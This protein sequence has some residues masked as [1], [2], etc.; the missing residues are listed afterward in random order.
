[1]LTRKELRAAARNELSGFWTMPV[2][3]TLVYFLINSLCGVPSVLSTAFP[4]NADVIVGFSSAYCVISILVILP[5]SYGFYLCFLKFLRG[6]KEDTVER[7]FDGFKTYGRALGVVILQSIFTILWTL[8]LIV[9]GIIKAFAYSMSVYISHD[10]PELSA[11]ECID[12]SV[13][14]MKGHKWEL[15]VLYLSFIGWF[16]L[17]LPTFG[18]GFLWLIP[19]VNVTVSKFYEE[20]KAQEEAELNEQRVEIME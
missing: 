15:F 16:I 8:L 17:C 10:H 3:A 1:M 20:L 6:S 9:P 2:L 14:M 4:T 13:D 11:N 19:Y 12:R 18:I 7:M 5:L